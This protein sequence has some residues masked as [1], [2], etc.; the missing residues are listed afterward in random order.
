[1]V[2]MEGLDDGKLERIT[3][4]ANIFRGA[5]KRS[6]AI[7]R[8]RGYISSLLFCE[9]KTHQ[10]DLIDY[11]AYRPP[12]V[13]RPSKELAGSI[14]QVQK[15]TRKALRLMAGQNEKLFKP[16]GS[17]TNI[18]FGTSRPHQAIII[19]SL[20]DLQSNFGANGE[21]VES[22][23]LF[24][25]SISDTEVITFDELFRRASFIVHD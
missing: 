14:A 9:I 22:F 17:A 23:E 24:R 5:G 21:Q 20:R 25:S 10:K 7:L 6:D 12:D 18:D 19:G 1:L 8:S 11:E 13:Y 4:G 15:T 3:T 2:A 16:D